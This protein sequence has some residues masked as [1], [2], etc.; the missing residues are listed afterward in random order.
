[1]ALTPAKRRRFKA[2]V[3]GMRARQWAFVAKASGEFKRSGVVERKTPFGALV[4]SRS[5]RAPG[6]F[7]VTTFD[8]DGNPTGH[9]ERKTLRGALT[10]LYEYAQSQS[11]RTLTKADKRGRQAKGAI[12][13]A[14][15]VQRR[16]PRIVLGRLV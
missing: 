6:T 14:K 5:A 2:E 7:Q 15:A 4:L 11:Y 1:M 3:K 16:L 10:E 9:T 12:P 8:R 13:P